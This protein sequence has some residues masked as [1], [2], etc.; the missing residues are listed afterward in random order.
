MKPGVLIR[1]MLNQSRQYEPFQGM[2]K[3]DGGLPK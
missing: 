1:E 3:V 2:V